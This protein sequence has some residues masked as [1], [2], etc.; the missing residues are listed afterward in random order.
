MDRSD[1]LARGVF[2]QVL[3][4]ALRI[5]SISTA[6]LWQRVVTT[7]HDSELE[8]SIGEET[9]PSS[10]AEMTFSSLGR[11][12]LQL[13]SEA[14]QAIAEQ[15]RKWLTAAL[16]SSIDNDGRGPLDNGQQSDASSFES[17]AASGQTKQAALCFEDWVALMGR[18]RAA[19]D[20]AC[21]SR[22]MANDSSHGGYAML[23]VLFAVYCHGRT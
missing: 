6:K 19:E 13:S 11:K 1:P 21:R 3:E 20:V 12:G 15:E 8:H 17:S 22:R 5:S 7:R 9:S 2:G 23:A 16:K 14:L 18:L 4:G 10:K